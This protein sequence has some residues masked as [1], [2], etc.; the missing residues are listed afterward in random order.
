[1][2]NY[3]E[4]HNDGDD[5]KDNSSKTI[6]TWKGHLKPQKLS[7]SYVLDLPHDFYD[8]FYSKSQLNY[9]PRNLIISKPINK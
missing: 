3:N 1:M 4:I 5:K 2:N 9:I 8:Q 6:N 7:Q